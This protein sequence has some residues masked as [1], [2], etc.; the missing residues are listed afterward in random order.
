[1]TIQ[2]FVAEF[3]VHHSAQIVALR[4]SESGSAALI[5]PGFGNNLFD[6]RLAPPAG[7][8]PLCVIPPPENLDDLRNRPSGW[9]TPILFP[10]PGRVRDG[11]FVYGGG[12][13]NATEAGEEKTSHGFVKNRAWRVDKCWADTE[14][15]HV[16][17][18]I[19]SKD[20]PE[21]VEL[22]PGAWE[23]HFRYSLTSHALVASVEVYNPGTTP[24]PFGLGLHPYFA[25]PCSPKGTRAACQ[26]QSSARLTWDLARVDAVEAETGAS[27]QVMTCPVGSDFYWS[28]PASLGDRSFDAV[29]T[30]MDVNKGAVEYGVTDPAAGAGVRVSA[31]ENFPV[32]VVY[33]SPDKSMVCLEPWTCPPNVFNLAH[34]GIPG[35]GLIELAPDAIW[36]G[37]MRIELGNIRQ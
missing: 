24:L 10:W 32:L 25:T 27:G 8:E 14:G 16:L 37:W 20:Y 23:L 30:D 36:R 5:W 2:R 12:E 13:Y 35:A 31:S 4:D 22:F 1:M 21:L 11:R 26:M 17:C 34:A 33:T 15:A 29:L 19:A 28:T 9:G 6:L 7:G 3:E 18:S